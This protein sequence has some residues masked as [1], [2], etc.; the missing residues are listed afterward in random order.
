M[1]VSPLQ[2]KRLGWLLLMSAAALLFQGVNQFSSALAT[3]LGALW[4]LMAFK[5]ASDALV[6]AAYGREGSGGGG[7][8]VDGLALRQV[9][10]GAGLLGLVWLAGLFGGAGAQLACLA[11]FAL[12]LPAMVIVLV[13]ERSLPRA[14]D[15]L[16]WY[17]L[18]RRVGSDY[19]ALVFKLT[20]MGAVFALALVFLFAPLQ[21][22]LATTAMH[23]LALY[24]LLAGYHAMGVLVHRHQAALGLPA[25]GAQAEARPALSEEELALRQC[26][27]L[28]GAGR[29]DE[30]AATLERF[31]HA[32]G[33]SAALHARYRELLTGLGD[34]QGLLRHAH[35]YVA[36]LLAQGKE[37]EAMALYL[38]SRAMYGEFE[39]Q[40][41][42]LLRE[43]G[44]AAARNQQDKLA[45]A[46]SE[47]LARRFPEAGAA[48]DYL[49]PD[50]ATGEMR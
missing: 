37:R 28:V 19:L 22:W 31:I 4:W 16:S 12:L 42:A 25:S 34:H 32:H 8:S 7:F 30:G 36:V 2:G 33:G 45:A 5:L 26:A 6:A 14:I 47:E 48:K 29:A 13:L 50:P 17:R 1:L 24:A 41:P 35:G 46:L 10:L 18:L 11:V 21:P 40:D 39:L 44:A 15:P 23:F 9:V 43:L 38:A 49:E 3:L 20:A 27:D